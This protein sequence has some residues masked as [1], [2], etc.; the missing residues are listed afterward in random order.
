MTSGVS[1]ID[2]L[3]GGGRPIG[4]VTEL[5]GLAS[6]GGTSLAFSLLTRATAGSACAY[7]DVDDT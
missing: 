4:G 2:G 6:S 3:L 5:T 1:E 7:I